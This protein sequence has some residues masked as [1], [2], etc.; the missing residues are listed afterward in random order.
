VIAWY[1]G[2]VGGTRPHSLQVQHCLSSWFIN[3][4]FDLLE[5]F[6]FGN[7]ISPSQDIEAAAYLAA[8][9][10]TIHASIRFELRNNATESIDYGMRQ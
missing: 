8:D 3:G 1:L 4:S 5:F 2:R 10:L 7:N 6:S 9:L